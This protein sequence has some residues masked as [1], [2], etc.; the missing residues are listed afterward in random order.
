MKNR[1]IALEYF[2]SNNVGIEGLF[3]LARAFRSS[4]SPALSPLAAD[5]LSR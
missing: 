5:S 1:L 2:L 4:P 3:T